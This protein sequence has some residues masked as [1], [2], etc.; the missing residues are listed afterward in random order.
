MTDRRI[1][2]IFFEIYKWRIGKWH[3]FLHKNKP[4]SRKITVFE[5]SSS[6]TCIS[7]KKLLHLIFLARQQNGT[8]GDERRVC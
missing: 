7:N 1:Q 6:A 4:E 3:I 8:W 5:G 2:T